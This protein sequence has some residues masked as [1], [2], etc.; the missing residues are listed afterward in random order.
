MSANVLNQSPITFI[1]DTFGYLRP[2]EPND[3]GRFL[4]AGRGLP[5][6]PL[7]FASS[8]AYVCQSWTVTR[9]GHNQRLTGMRLLTKPD[10]YWAPPR[11]NRLGTGVPSPS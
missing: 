8:P 11:H 5:S 6:P 7:A 9:M 1:H 4:T 3:R 2:R 10:C